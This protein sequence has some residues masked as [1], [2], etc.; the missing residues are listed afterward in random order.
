M[1]F[2]SH[3]IRLEGFLLGFGRGGVVSDVMLSL[4]E[5]REGISV[6][7]WKAVRGFHAA[8]V[9]GESLHPPGAPCLLSGVTGVMPVL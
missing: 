3:K 1:W 6:W 9:S 2:E 5:M 4:V 7:V 8:L